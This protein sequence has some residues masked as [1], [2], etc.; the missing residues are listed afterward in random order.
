MRKNTS[1]ELKAKINGLS[2]FLIYV[3]SF[4]KGNKLNNFFFMSKWTKTK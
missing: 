4:Q 1:D 3:E 2:F